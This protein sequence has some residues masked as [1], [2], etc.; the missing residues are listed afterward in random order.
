MMRLRTPSRVHLTYCKST[1]FGDSWAEVRRTIEG[2]IA[3]MRRRVAPNGR[4]GISL[5][6]SSRVLRELLAPGARAELEFVLGIHQLYVFKIEAK[7]HRPDW[8]EHARLAQ[9]CR[10]ADLLASLVPEGLIGS[11][12]TVPGAQ[13]DRAHMRGARHAVASRLLAAA[14]HCADLEALT[15]RSIVLSIEPEPGFMLEGAFDT[16]S[17][18]RDHVFRGEALR[19]ARVDERTARRHLGVCLVAFDKPLDAL[20]TFEREGITVTRQTAEAA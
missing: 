11:I 14:A 5:R 4:L 15:G 7:E 17:F 13:G 10:A 18:F 12:S 19:A 1:E 8:L 9:T 3:A 2:P 20:A 16:V 6:L